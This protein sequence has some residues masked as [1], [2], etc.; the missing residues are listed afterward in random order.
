MTG[1]TI[2]L[3]EDNYLL[4]WWMTSSLQREG[5]VV[6]APQSPDEAIALAGAKSFDV[7]I[8]DWRLPEGHLGCEILTRV[9]EKSP[10]T[11]AIL[12]SAES[13]GE[14]TDQAR[15]CGF[16]L[17]IEKPFP[18]AEIIGAVHTLAG[19]LPAKAVC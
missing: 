6:S 8:T 9:R 5:W 15:A 18:V 4:R 12:I 13:G 16:D 17:V 14:F 10:R 11:L 2:L 3:V 7:V 1:P 19:R